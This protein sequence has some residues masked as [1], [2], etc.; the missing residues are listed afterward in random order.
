MLPCKILKSLNNKPEFLTCCFIEI[1][2][3]RIL[4]GVLCC[5]HWQTEDGFEMHLGVN[6]LGHF[7]L[8][9]LLMDMLKQSVPSRVVTIASYTHHGIVYL[10]I[11][12]PSK[13]GVNKYVYLGGIFLYANG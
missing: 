8:T 2:L 7:L 3:T 12:K 13:M 6:H 9:N 4:I 11:V 1:I 5:P 10:I